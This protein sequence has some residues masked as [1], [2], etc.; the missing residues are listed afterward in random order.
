MNKPRLLPPPTLTLPRKGGGNNSRNSHS[1][2]PPLRGRVGWGDLGLIL[3][4]LPARAELPQIRLDRIFPL[5]AEAGSEV[6]LEISGK[7]LDEAKSLHF[8]HPGFKAELTKP[9]EI[10]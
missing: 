1:F 7:D 3:L 10:K 5:G 8:D 4:T 6:T 9:N 2:P